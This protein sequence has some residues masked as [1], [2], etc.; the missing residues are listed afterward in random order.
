M[1]IVGTPIVASGTRLGVLMMRRSSNRKKKY[2]S[3][4]GTYVVVVGLALEPSSA[5]RTSDI[6]MMTAITITAMIESLATAYGKN[7]LPCAF[8]IE[9]S[10][11]YSSFSRWFIAS[12]SRSENHGRLVCAPWALY[13]CL[14]QLVALL[15]FRPRRRGGAEL[16]DE[17][18]V[19]AEQ[20]GDQS[21][22]EQHVDGIE[23]RKRGGAEFRA[24]AQEV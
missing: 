16:G 12:P 10:R 8:S 15:G 13:L 23:A 20:R 2:H 14:A 24:T 21:W 17:V 4:R 7:G 19:R 3:G 22:H 5:P 9:Y 11:R 1:Q 18:Q 6:V